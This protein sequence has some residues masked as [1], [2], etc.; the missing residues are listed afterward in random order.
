MEESKKKLLQ[1][2]FLNLE[3]INPFVLASAPPAKDYESIKKGFEAGWAGAVTKSVVLHQLKDKTP[4]IGHIKR[5]GNITASQNYEMGSDK[6]VDYWVKTVN[7]LREE[8]S[9]RMLYV[10]IF[11]GPDIGEWKEL[12]SIFKKTK[13][14]GL[15]L[16]FSCPHSEHNG[17][18]SVI[19]QNPDLC[20]SITSEVKKNAGNLKIMPKMTYLAHPN[21]G[22]IAKSCIESGADAICGINTIAGLSEIDPYSFLPKLNTGGKTAAGGIS[23]DLI[24]PFGRL[25]VANISKSIGEHPVSACGGISSNL[26]SM[27][28]YFA[29]GANHLQVCTEVMNKGYG[30]IDKMQKVLVDYLNETGRSLNEIRGIT[31]D[32]IV[33]WDK[34]DEKKRV[35]EISDKCNGCYSCFDVCDYEALKKLNSKVEVNASL[36]SG[37]GSCYA[38]CENDAIKMTEKSLRNKD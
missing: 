34:L 32:K 1:V 11:A 21:E 17:K 12:A 16:N 30:V 10:S 19:G 26:E 8:F 36:C 25:V 13:A 9:D 37:C 20:A 7:K 6:N 2:N 27:V 31:L 18:G 22:L 28:E 23:Y 24:R 38:T 33:T 35:A 4:R 29:L 5:K 14:H 3:L 15:E